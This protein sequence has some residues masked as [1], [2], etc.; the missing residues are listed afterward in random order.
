MSAT[1]VTPE[2]VIPPNAATPADQAKPQVNAAQQAQAGRAIL[3]TI[4]GAPAAISG[5]LA[6]V[7]TAINRVA[8]AAGTVM[9]NPAQ[10]AT[11]AI[12]AAT[13]PAPNVPTPVSG[14][15]LVGKVDQLQK[16][17][18][19]AFRQQNGIASDAQLTPE[20]RQQVNAQ[21][22]KQRDALYV[23]HGRQVFAAQNAA[24]EAD[25]Q[26]RGDTLGV[27]AAKGKRAVASLLSDGR[28]TKE[29]Q[30][31]IA[32]GMKAEAEKV[33]QGISQ[34]VK[35]ESAIGVMDFLKQNPEALLVPAGI[36]LALFGGKTGLLLGGLA[37]LW[38][39]KSMFDRYKGVTSPEFGKEFAEF[40]SDPNNLTPENLK[41]HNDWIRSP[42]TDPAEAARKQNWMTA[43]VFTQFAPGAVQSRIQSGFQD[44]LGVYTSPELAAQTFGAAQ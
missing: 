43:G 22:V 23:Q 16:A 34:A 41:K 14:K 15:E 21:F 11:T 18:E 6:G 5:A 37:A 40:H 9:A 2:P 8:D 44:Q 19:A 39:G 12:G 13:S 31:E 26:K 38:G 32:S 20:Q 33:K 27:L 36:L 17:N 10:A 3:D 4:S 7:P 30:Q 42:S 25:A 29:V 35:Q 1:G 28:M 24:E